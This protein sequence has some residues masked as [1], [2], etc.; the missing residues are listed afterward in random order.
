MFLLLLVIK[1]S[2]C[3]LYCD[4]NCLMEFAVILAAT[5][6]LNFPR[7]IRRFLRVIWVFSE[8]RA[9]PLSAPFVCVCLI[10]PRYLLRQPPFLK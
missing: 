8:K 1:S 4:K 7:A 3:G 9:I 2:P 5:C 10:A 6:R